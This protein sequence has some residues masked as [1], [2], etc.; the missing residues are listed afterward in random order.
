MGLSGPLRD[1]DSDVPRYQGRPNRQLVQSMR[2]SRALF[3]GTPAGGS[4][5]AGAQTKSGRGTK[6]EARPPIIQVDFL[7]CRSKETRQTRPATKFRPVMQ[8]GRAGVQS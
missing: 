3:E 5:S 2:F 1:R 6:S 8:L 4:T 7:L